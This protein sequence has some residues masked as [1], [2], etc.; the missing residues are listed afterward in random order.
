VFND[1]K[2]LWL[3]QQYIINSHP[4][5]IARHLSYQ[6][7]LIG[8]D[9]TEGPD[10]MDVVAAQR[11]RAS[12][13]VEMAQISEFVYRDFEAFD[14]TAAKKNLRPA[15]KEPLEKLRAGLAAV[16][17]WSPETAYQVVKDVAEALEL[18]MGKVAQP[19]RVAIVGRAASPSIDVTLNLVGQAASLRRIDKALAYIDQREAQG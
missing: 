13:L 5:H 3:S 11:E 10:I 17:S 15:A 16:E 7:G 1:E 14:E 8:I 4:E 12:T 18:K 19:L 6:L 2:L 9:P